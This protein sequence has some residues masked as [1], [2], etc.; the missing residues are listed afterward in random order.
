MRNSLKAYLYILPALLLSLVFV[1]SPFIWSVV[2]SFF[3]V[4]LDGSFASPA[5][6]RN[7]VNLLTDSIYWESLANTFR[8]IILFVP[9]NIILIMFAVLLTE[10]ENRHNRVFETVFMLPM[11]MGMSSAALIFK[12]MFR[13]SVG[14]VNRLIG[15][16]VQW[17][18]DAEAAMLSVVFLGIFLDFGLDY[19]LLLSGLRNLDRSV[20]DAA[21]LDGAGEWQVLTRIKLPLLSPT[22]FFTLFISLK[23]A[24]LIS[25][26]VMVMTEGGPFR[27]TQTIVYYYYIEA[28]RN[29]NHSSA[30]AI[31]VTVFILAAL[32][33]ACSSLVDRR[34]IHYEN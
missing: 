2:S 11:A 29:G 8:F 20:Q 15:I 24:L 4:R 1:Y 14:I 10:K 23:D 34:R 12:Y 27:S 17:T 26:P 21:R 28:F 9:S 19:L 6:L 16:D 33:T 18:N 3:N 13:P 22:L 31:S 30:A 32:I 7:Y 5:G 25:A